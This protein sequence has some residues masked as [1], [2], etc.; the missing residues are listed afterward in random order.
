MVKTNGFTL[1]TLF[2]RLMALAYLVDATLKTIPLA[3]NHFGEDKTL[4]QQDIYYY[5]FVLVF[6]MLIWLFA[7]VLAKFALARKDAEL[8][9]SSM[10]P[11]EWAKLL[12]AGL[13]VW[14]VC[15]AIM[16]MAYF[17]GF[18]FSLKEILEYD[19]SWYQKIFLPGVASCIAQLAIGL[20]LFFGSTGLVRIFQ[21]YRHY[22]I[23]SGSDEASV[24]IIQ[25]K[26]Q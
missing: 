17:S 5:L 20:S 14:N 2:V 4:L 6:F 16:D 9:E 25:D 7:D 13:G 23:P 11:E 15:V 12:F 8:F 1:L 22:G 3:I 24:A 21:R 10:Q 26:Q 18:L 19:P